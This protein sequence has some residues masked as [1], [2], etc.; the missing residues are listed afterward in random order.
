MKL[1]K[2]LLLFC[3]I[4][5]G[6]DSVYDEEDNEAVRFWAFENSFNLPLQLLFVL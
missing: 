4:D 1:T 2:F 3:R 5:S 6:V